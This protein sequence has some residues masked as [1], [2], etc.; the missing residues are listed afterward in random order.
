MKGIKAVIFDLDGTLLDTI[1]DLADSCNKTLEQLGMPPRTLDEVRSFVGNGIARL[2]EQAVP[3]GKD[4]KDFEKSVE[5]MKKNYGSNWHNKTKPYDGIMELIRSL[6]DHG[7]KIGINSNKPDQ[8]VKEL[9][10][11]FFSNVVGSETAL[12]DKEGIN[13][14]PAPDL[15]NELMKIFGVSKEETVYV[16]DSDVDI[17]TARNA[18]IKCISVT[19]GF[20]SREFL[21]EHGAEFFADTPDEILDIIL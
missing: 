9:G 5:L 14:K 19:W 11:L 8:Q 21:E 4:N 10:N 15:A 13:R 17:A 12:G 6:K 16:G 1:E 3:K 7:I 18:G 20:R 2:M